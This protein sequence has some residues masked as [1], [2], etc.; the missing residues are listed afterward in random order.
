M[1]SLEVIQKSSK[2][3]MFKM[4]LIQIGTNLEPQVNQPSEPQFKM[5]ALLMVQG[6][7]RGHSVSFLRRQ[8]LKSQGAK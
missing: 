3:V 6:K 1:Q 4:Q 7:T 2:N 5:R 8:R